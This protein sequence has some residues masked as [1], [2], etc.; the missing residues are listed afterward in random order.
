MKKI[1]NITDHPETEVETRVV[2]VFGQKI[3]PGGY[4]RVEDEQLV[5]AHKL[6]KDIAAGLVSVGDEPPAGYLIAKGVMPAATVKSRVQVHGESLTPAIEPPKFVKP[7]AEE[8][9]V[10]GVKR[11]GK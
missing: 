8:G 4:I 2:V 11:K 3:L 9:P 5:N 1:W 10:F 6:E 7:K